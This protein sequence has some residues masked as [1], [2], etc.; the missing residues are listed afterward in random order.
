MLMRIPEYPV[1]DQVEN[2]CGLD[3]PF[4]DHTPREMMVG[5]IALI[6]LFVIA[7]LLRTIA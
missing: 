1:Q 2:K 3:E 7:I 5:Q 4:I 6:L